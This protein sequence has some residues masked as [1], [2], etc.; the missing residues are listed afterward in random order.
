MVGADECVWGEDFFSTYMKHARKMS[1]NNDILHLS[2]ALSLVGQSLRD[3]YL[4][5]DQQHI[6]CRIHPF[7]IQSSGTGKGSTFSLIRKVA[8]AADIPFEKEGKATTAGLAGTVDQ[9]GEQRAGDLKGSGFLGWTEAQ[10]L[11]KSAD[12]QHSSDIMEFLNMAMDPSGEIA[13]TLSKGKLEYESNTSIFCTTYDPEPNGQLELIR[14]GFLPRTLFFYRIMGEEFYDDIN[15]MRDKKIPRSFNSENPQVREMDKDIQ[16]LANTLKFVE[17]TVWNHGKT[18]RRDE[19]H[20]AVAREH[21]DYFYVEKGVSLNPS[22]MMDEVLED[23]PIA[24]RHKAKAFKTR[25]MDSVYRLAACFA[26]VDYDEEHDVY[27]SRRIR[28]RHVDRAMTICEQSFGH[29]LDFI[30]DYSTFSSNNQLK[31]TERKINTIADNNGGNAT[32]KELMSETYRSKEQIKS[33][34]ITL[35]Y[36]DKVE[37][38]DSKPIQ[39][40]SIDDKVKPKA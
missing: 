38:V 11:L 37:M 34:I 21:I 24:V 39:A 36:M 28:E 10:T 40:V 17:N 29:I 9:S 35:E 20:F 5:I 15:E 18:Y 4:Q 33:D 32:I 19:T 27:V 31:E 22:P 23:Y 8:R 6:D 25:M 2:G 14:Q 7:I 3:V 13:K 1:Y 12:Q 16:K 30:E 26:A